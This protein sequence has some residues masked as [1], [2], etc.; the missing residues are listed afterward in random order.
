MARKNKR[1]GKQP[2]AGAGKSRKEGKPPVDPA[3]L[4]PSHMGGSRVCSPEQKEQVLE[5]LRSLPADKLEAIRAPT[6]DAPT[7][8]ETS[9]LV[10]LGVVVPTN[11]RRMPSTKKIKKYAQK[12]DVP[13]VTIVNVTLLQDLLGAPAEGKIW[14]LRVS[15]IEDAPKLDPILSLAEELKSNVDAV[16]EKDHPVE[17]KDDAA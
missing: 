14:G 12:L 2:P 3:S 17:G 11:V 7:C 13:F 6:T 15:G 16:G 9:Q 1:G 5:F 4:T 10:V 8:T